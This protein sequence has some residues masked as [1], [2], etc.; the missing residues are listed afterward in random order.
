M[1]VLTHSSEPAPRLIWIYAIGIGAFQGMNAIL[2]LFLAARFGVTTHTIGYFYTYIGVISVLTRALILGWA[3]DRYG[4]ARLSRLGQALLAIGLAAMPFMHRMNDPAA[5][6]AR[7]GGI[8]PVS[9][10]R[11]HSVS[12]AGAGRCI[13]S[14]RNG[15]HF[16]LCHSPALARHSK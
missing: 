9:A 12:A 2:A 4:E 8:L 1:H 13:A 7:L 3:V 6:A 15:L 5:F 14:A 10:V 16:S 11:I